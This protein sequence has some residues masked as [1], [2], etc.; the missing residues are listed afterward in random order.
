MSAITLTQYLMG[1]DQT[2]AAELTPAILA[3]AKELLAR[4]NELLALAAEHG[5]APGKDT[6]TGTAVASGWRP[7]G[8]NAR[9]ANAASSSTHLTGE[10]IDLQDY[11]DKR[12]ARFCLH[13]REAMEH[14]GLWAEDPRWTHG[15]TGLD[16]WVHLQSRAPKSGMRFYIPSTAP[17]QC[18]PLSP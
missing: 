14:I 5:I 2:H 4:V 12:L 18:P 17:A 11:P 1:R 7:A 10:G 13:N 8:V 16:P 6:V 9:T 15:K 3:N